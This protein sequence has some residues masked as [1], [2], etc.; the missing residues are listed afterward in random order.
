MQ[1][2][3]AAEPFLAEVKMF[4]GNF[5]PRGYALCDGQLLT[6]NQYQAVFALLGTI[7]GGDGRTSFALPDL[8][9]RTAIHPG[10]GPGLGSYRL[11]QKAGF[12]YVTLTAA[13]M[14]SHNHAATSKGIN[15]SGNTSMPGG[16][17][18]ASKNRTN[19]YSTNAPAVDMHAG[20]VTVANAGGGQ[21]HENRMPYLAINH[22]IALQ[23]LFPSRN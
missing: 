1:Q 9:G 23:G 12:E 15:S 7:Y 4:A 8:R 13:Q 20:S 2:T 22:I 6:I 5:A 11:G 14:P 21:H 10:Q 3:Q 18:L 17:T 16:N 19:I